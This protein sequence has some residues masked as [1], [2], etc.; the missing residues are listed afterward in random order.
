MKGFD[1]L[2]ILMDPRFTSMLWLGVKMTLIVAVCSWLRVSRS[3]R[4]SRR[5]GVLDGL[6]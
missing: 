1:V 3:S 6:R 4:A 2:A 5:S